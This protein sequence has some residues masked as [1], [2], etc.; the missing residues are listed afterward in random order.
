V[1]PEQTV[2]VRCYGLACGSWHLCAR[3]GL[4]IRLEDAAEGLAL[5]PHDG[6]AQG[7]G[8]HMAWLR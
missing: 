2:Q 8:L 7:R 3:T 5:L 4:A 1:T 6:Q